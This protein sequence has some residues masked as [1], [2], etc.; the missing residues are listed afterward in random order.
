ME[1]NTYGN[2]F[3]DFMAQSYEENRGWELREHPNVML[4]L[5]EE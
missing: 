2:L 3:W 4:I 1:L 5:K